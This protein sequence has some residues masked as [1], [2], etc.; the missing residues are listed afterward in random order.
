VDRI[1]DLAPGKRIHAEKMV[2]PDEDYFGDHFPGLPV[3]P[4]VLQTEMMAQAAGKCLDAEDSLRGKAMLAK[5]VSASFREWVKPGC[6]CHI[7]AQVRTSRPRFAT[8]EAWIE[9][10]GR[11]VADAELFFTFIPMQEFAL[12]Y[13]DEVLDA[14]MNPKAAE[15]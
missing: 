11:R 6:T 2:S 14:F 9:V 13:R 15:K 12:G 5:I 4:G 7:Y 3:V 1:L 10:E 8:A